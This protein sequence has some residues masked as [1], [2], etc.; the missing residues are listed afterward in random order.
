MNKIKN[1]S[2]F[3]RIFFQVLFIASPIFLII[4]WIQAP[5]PISL[6]D[7]SIRMTFIPNNYA[8]MHPLSVNERLL[9]FLVNMLP[10]AVELFILYSLIQLFK[11]YGRGEIF[12]L[13]NVRHIRNIGYALIVG[14]LINPI[15]EGLM[16][17]IVTIH[18]PPGHRYAS[19]T[20]DQT[21]IGL[22]IMALIVILISWIM[23]EGCRLREEQQLTV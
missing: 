15:Y 12:S 18:N 4:G 10:T 1:V 21:N 23:T 6:L 2:L 9:G 11:M 8:I 14:Q 22:L 17:V 3:F 20:F 13:N 16:G 19:I 5:Q 7:N